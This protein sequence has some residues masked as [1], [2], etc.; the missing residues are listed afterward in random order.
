ME[1]LIFFCRK[2]RFLMHHQETFL[3]YQIPFCYKLF[4]Y[5]IH[6]TFEYFSAAFS[7]FRLT[8]NNRFYCDLQNLFVSIATRKEFE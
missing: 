7:P 8:L 6:R 5:Q 2:Y 3:L 1:F 4:S